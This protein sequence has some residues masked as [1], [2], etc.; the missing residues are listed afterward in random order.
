MPE[1]KM[2]T[3]GKLSR[4]MLTMVSKA[5]TNKYAA[6]IKKGLVGKMK[7]RMKEKAKK[8]SF[9]INSKKRSA[10]Y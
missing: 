1:G 4:E 5:G 10:G 7:E 6:E 3:Y 8:R 2:S 9:T